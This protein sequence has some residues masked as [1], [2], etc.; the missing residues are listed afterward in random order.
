MWVILTSLSTNFKLD[1]ESRSRSRTVRPTK[2]GGGWERGVEYVGY[3][4]LTLNQL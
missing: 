1:P 4:D 3:I 2:G